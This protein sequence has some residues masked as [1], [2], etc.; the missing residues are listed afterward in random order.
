VGTYDNGGLISS[1]DGGKSWK[2]YN[3]SPAF[4]KCRVNA[5]IATPDGGKIYAAPDCDSAKGLYISIDNGRSWTRKT[6]D[7]GLGGNFVRS[8][9][10]LNK[11]LFVGSIC[12]GG[13]SISNDSGLTWSVKTTKQGLP[14]N[15]V[16]SLFGTT[17]GKIYAGTTA[18]LA[19][20]T[21]NGEQWSRN[22]GLGKNLTYSV[23]VTDKGRILA[24]TEQGLFLSDDDGWTWKRLLKDRF[25]AVAADGASIYAGVLAGAGS[26]WISSDDGNT[27]QEHCL[28]NPNVLSIFLSYTICR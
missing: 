28:D 9:V 18:G 11:Q 7:D 20:S 3:V 17:G 15:D 4:D 26:L 16:Y 24:G 14:S 13:V 25:F 8:V 27:W 10:L 2:K 22:E 5:V 19:M 6:T 21:N 1:I 23:F 12:S